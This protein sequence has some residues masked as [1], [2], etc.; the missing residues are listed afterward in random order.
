LINFHRT[1]TSLVKG[2][3]R[4][5]A[6]ALSIAPALRRAI[7][8]LGKLRPSRYRPDRRIP[9]LRSHSILCVGPSVG[10]E[11]RL[12]PRKIAQHPQFSDSDVFESKKRSALPVHHQSRGRI[13]PEITHVD[14]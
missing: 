12:K 4:G 9:L 8:P 3:I 14:S 1:L 7:V 5:S 10:L 2:S 6:A 13:A 11:N